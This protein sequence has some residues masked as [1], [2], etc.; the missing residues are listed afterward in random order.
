MRVGEWTL[1]NFARLMPISPFAYD[2]RHCFEVL[3]AS[4]ATF[5]SALTTRHTFSI[6]HI[7]DTD[8][9]FV[10]INGLVVDVDLI[11]RSATF[12]SAY[13]TSQTK[14]GLYSE[15]LQDVVVTHACSMFF[16]VIST[17]D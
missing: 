4:S 6:L 10:R 13:V 12:S 8:S 11:D 2:A 7:S 3:L 14:R 1:T 5:L 17:T 15:A 9:S 16:G